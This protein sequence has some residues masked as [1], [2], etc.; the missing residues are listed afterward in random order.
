MNDRLVDM[1]TEDDLSMEAAC[2]G[3]INGHLSTITYNADQRYFSLPNTHGAMI[4]T[5]AKINGLLDKGLAY[6]LYDTVRT[7]KS[8][9]GVRKAC[10]TVLINY[11]VQNW[12]MR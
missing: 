1:Y 9:H 2:I 8:E 12:K 7:A 3:K 4:D 6:N 11:V 5:D 10:K